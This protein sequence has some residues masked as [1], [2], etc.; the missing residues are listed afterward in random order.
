MGDF[1]YVAFRG[2]YQAPM[3]GSDRA[4]AQTDEYQKDLR[5]NE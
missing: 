2:F 1:A 3:E 5:T 4:R